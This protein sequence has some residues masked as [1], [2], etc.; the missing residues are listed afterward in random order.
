M[1]DT[2]SDYEFNERIWDYDFN[3]SDFEYSEASDIEYGLMDPN[4]LQSTAA[5]SECGTASKAD[6]GQQVTLKFCK[7]YKSHT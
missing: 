3:E 6:Q 1:S 2:F 4:M 7:I 5:I